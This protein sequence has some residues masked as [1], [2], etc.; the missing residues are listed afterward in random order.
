MSSQRKLQT[1]AFEG[2][3]HFCQLQQ[4]QNYDT[5]KV[6]IL[7][8]PAKPNQH[9]KKNQSVNQCSHNLVITTHTEKSKHQFHNQWQ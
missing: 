3:N 7:S 5:L 2:G 9:K 8:V 1:D 4:N 6:T